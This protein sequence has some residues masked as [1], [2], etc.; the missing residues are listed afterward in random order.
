[1]PIDGK[2]TIE[3]RYSFTPLN[4]CRLSYELRQFK[5]PADASTGFDVIGKGSIAA[6][7]I[8]PG[9]AGSIAIDRTAMVADADATGDPNRK[10]IRA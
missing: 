1:M 4:E 9:E 6:P 8:A 3:N 7:S 5:S 2:F 10:S